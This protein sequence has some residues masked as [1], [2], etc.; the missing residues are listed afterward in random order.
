MCTQ[1][2]NHLAIYHA[3][4]AT[5]YIHYYYILT[6]YGSFLD[7]RSDSQIILYVCPHLLPLRDIKDEPKEG[8]CPPPLLPKGVKDDQSEFSLPPYDVKDECNEGGCPPP[9]PPK[10]VNDIP[11]KI[12]G[13]LIS[14]RS[15]TEMALERSSPQMLSTFSDVFDVRDVILCILVPIVT[16]FIIWV[17]I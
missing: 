9:L 8:Q 7:C 14:G 16:Q 4:D 1:F 13:D 6:L 11:G 15:K 3:H 5:Y 10:K 12:S 17:T 2:K